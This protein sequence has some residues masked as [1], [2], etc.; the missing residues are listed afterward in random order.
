M[1]TA[2]RV[3]VEAMDE[4]I[5]AGIEEFGGDPRQALRALLHD[6]TQLAVYAEGVG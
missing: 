6:L 1:K 2:E 3:A 5:G 4:E